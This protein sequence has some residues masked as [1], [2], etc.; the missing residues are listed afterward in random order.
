LASFISSGISIVDHQ[1]LWVA[2][3]GSQI[4][5]GCSLGVRVNNVEKNF[6]VVTISYNLRTDYSFAGANIASGNDPEPG[7]VTRV[8]GSVVNASQSVVDMSNHSR[9]E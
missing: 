5:E 9:P 1:D 6:C 4:N 7:T 8:P 2:G 3:K